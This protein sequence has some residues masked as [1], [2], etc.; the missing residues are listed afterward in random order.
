MNSFKQRDFLGT[1]KGLSDFHRF[2]EA[3]SQIEHD[4][5]SL[6]RLISRFLIKPSNQLPMK[7]GE[8]SSHLRAGMENLRELMEN[9][10]ID[11][12]I[13]YCVEVE[14][15]VGEVLKKAYEILQRYHG[16]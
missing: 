15:R 9:S 10:G 11:S 7:I 13:F 1:S 2:K 8:K 6:R 5:V 16:L 12:G 3:F 4:E 14:A